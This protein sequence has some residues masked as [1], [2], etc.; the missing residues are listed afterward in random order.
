MCV[1]G[2]KESVDHGKKKRVAN[3]MAQTKMEKWKRY[4]KQ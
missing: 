2:L 3:L 1:C 4:Q